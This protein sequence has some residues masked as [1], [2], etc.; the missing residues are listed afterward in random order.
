M[1]AGA[2]WHVVLG[3]CVLMVW[4]ATTAWAEEALA[5]ALVDWLVFDD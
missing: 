2:M 5:L 1:T 3:S 4:A